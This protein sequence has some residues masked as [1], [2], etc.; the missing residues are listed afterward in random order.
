MDLG[1]KR[2][3]AP[4]FFHWKDGKLVGSTTGT[5]EKQEGAY[6]DLTDEMKAD[7]KEMLDAFF[8]V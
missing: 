8:G 4:N 5:S 6:D 1:E 2:I 7:E 3:Y